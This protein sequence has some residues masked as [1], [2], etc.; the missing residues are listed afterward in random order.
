[1]LNIEILYKF[2]SRSTI[3]VATYLIGGIDN[4]LTALIILIIIDYVTGIL[5]SI[6][7]KNFKIKINIEGVIRKVGYYFI[8]I[9][10]TILDYIIGDSSMAIR[11]LTI[12]FFIANEAISI[13]ENWASIG[14][15][16]P[17]KLYE[18]FENLK[19]FEKNI[20]KERNE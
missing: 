4:L 14:L 10:A 11:T 9:L 5:K 20:E 19:N 13:L 1:M 8:V 15:P 16:L 18:I 7:Q 17:K 6:Y 2:V 12:Y 3:S